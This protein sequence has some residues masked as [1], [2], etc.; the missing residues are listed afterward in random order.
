MAPIFADTICDAY[1]G[2]TSYEAIY[3]RLED[4]HPK[5]TIMRAATGLTKPSR[6]QCKDASCSFF[7]WIGARAKILP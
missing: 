5:I 1:G 2:T 7:H 6:P 3:N 4:E